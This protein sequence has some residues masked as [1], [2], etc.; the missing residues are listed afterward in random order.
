VDVPLSVPLPLPP[1]AEGAGLRPAGRF[2]G[3]GG[4][5]FLPATAPL[6]FGGA[7][8][9]ERACTGGGGGGAG[10]ATTSSRYADGAHPE[11]EPSMRFASHHPVNLLAFT[12]IS[13]FHRNIP[14]FSFWVTRIISSLVRLSSPA[15]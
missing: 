1:G 13:Q 3:G 4:G 8:G 15:V 7:G 5:I 9:I 14:L 6:A 10:L 11:A 12:P 2:A